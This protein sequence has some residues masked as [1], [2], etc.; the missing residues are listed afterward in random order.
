[1]V[2][3]HIVHSLGGIFM[4]RP[5]T[6]PQAFSSMK[7]HVQ[8]P[9]MNFRLRGTSGLLNQEISPNISQ[10]NSNIDDGYIEVGT[11]IVTDIDDTVKSSGGIKLF[12]IPLGGIDV[13]FQ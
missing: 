2:F 9:L 5:S 11:R 3:S 10:S 7:K 4:P 6:L 8:F 1:M 13:S 12:G